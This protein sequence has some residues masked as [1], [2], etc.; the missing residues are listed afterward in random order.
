MRSLTISVQNVLNGRMDHKCVSYLETQL[1]ITV[2]Y[3]RFTY[4]EPRIEAQKKLI[5][6]V[7]E[8]TPLEESYLSLVKL[9][10]SY[11]PCIRI[12]AAAFLNQP[13]AQCFRLVSCR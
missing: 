8:K 13:Y 5:L 11:K 6:C 7:S 3:T 4:S 10:R 1:I 9:G 12:Q 2:W